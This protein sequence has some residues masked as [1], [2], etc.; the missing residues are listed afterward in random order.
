MQGGL[1]IWG[2]Y[3][4]F[5]VFSRSAL[6]STE[7]PQPPKQIEKGR[8][9]ILLFVNTTPIAYLNCLL[10]IK[11]RRR[12]VTVLHSQVT[13]TLRES[14][15]FFKI[16][17]TCYKFVRLSQSVF[18]QLQSLLPKMTCV[19]KVLKAISKS[20]IFICGSADYK[21]WPNLSY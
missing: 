17:F 10:E 2:L 4:Y 1:Q 11:K 9:R 21:S 12:G 18:Q 5:D 20:K 19:I 8:R 6:L 14:T 15:I 3:I 7:T 13:G 16:Y